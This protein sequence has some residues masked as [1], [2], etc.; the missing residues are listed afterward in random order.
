MVNGKHI[1]KLFLKGTLHTH[2]AIDQINQ[3]IGCQENS[4]NHSYKLIVK[5]MLSG[6]H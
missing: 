6:F 5:C 2:F 1:S 4:E 3:E